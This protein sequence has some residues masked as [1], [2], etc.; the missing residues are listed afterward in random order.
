[1]IKLEVDQ[2]YRL[3]GAPPIYKETTTE[4][5]TIR[6]TA[7]AGPCHK[8]T[9]I[10]GRV[11]GKSPLMEGELWS[12]SDLHAWLVPT[13]H[14]ILLP[15]LQDGDFVISTL[16]GSRAWRWKDSDVDWIVRDG[17]MKNMRYATKSET[18][19]ARGPA[20]DTNSFKV[21]D[22]VVS[23]GGTG[24]IPPGFIYQI[25][26]IK[27]DFIYSKTFPHSW[28]NYKASQFRKATQL[29]TEAYKNTY[30][31]VEEWK[32]WLS[33][34][35]RS[36]FP[37]PASYVDV[38][39]RRYE[40]VSYDI[41]VWVGTNL[42]LCEGYGTIYSCGYWAAPIEKHSKVVIE[43]TI[44]ETK[45]LVQQDSVVIAETPSLSIRMDQIVTRGRGFNEKEF[46]SRPVNERLE[47]PIKKTRKSSIHYHINF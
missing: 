3:A 9:I 30:S 41:P 23:L 27:H 4:N 40:G 31:N 8:F 20:D 14:F 1:M 46:L 34:D 42:C 7:I 47:V 19:N 15:D 33:R 36:R 45:R 10:S 24:S 39:G 29:E 5:S 18:V 35:A 44:T 12:G 13:R 43:A 21:D 6:I 37:S 16:P 25:E 22:I 2:V 11:I 32:S 38:F 17:G 26:M 28:S